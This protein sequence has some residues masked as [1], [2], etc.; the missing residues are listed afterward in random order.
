MGGASLLPEG[1]TNRKLSQGEGL[2]SQ[3]G[4]TTDV[5]RRRVETS[6]KEPCSKSDPGEGSMEGEGDMNAQEE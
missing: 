2:G 1:L 6:I 3:D 4:P 5:N